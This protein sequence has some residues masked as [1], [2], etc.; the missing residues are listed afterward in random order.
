M[1]GGVEIS[2]FWDYS[3]RRVFLGNAYLQ[4]SD[5]VDGYHVIG[6]SVSL[7]RMSYPE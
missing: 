5:S 3:L 6:S 7:P 1:K 2:R 4:Q